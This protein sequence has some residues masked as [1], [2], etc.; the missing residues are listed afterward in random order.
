MSAPVFTVNINWNGDGS[1]MVDEVSRTIDLQITRGRSD[2]LQ[3]VQAGTCTLLM[4][5]DT[6]RFTP[7]Y[8]AGG[9]FGSLN[10]HK[11]VQIKVALGSTY[12]LFTGYITRIQ[13]MPMTR[14]CTITCQDKFLFL[15]NFHLN[16]AIV[17]SALTGDRITDVL[18]IVGLA[19]G[20]M[21]ID[22]GQVTLDHPYQRNTDALSGIYEYAASDLAGIVFIAAGGKVTYRDA[23]ARTLSTSQGTI[24][25]AQDI[26]YDRGEDN[27][28]TQIIL[29]GGSFDAGIVGSQVWSYSPLPLLLPASSTVVLNPN[30][31][32]PATAVITPVSGT[33]FIA[34]DAADGSGTDRSSLMVSTF[35]DYGGGAAWSITNTRDKDVYLTTI[36]VRG[37]PRGRNTS[38]RTVTRTG[39]SAPYVKTY[40]NSY[41]FITDLVTLAAFADYLASHFSLQQ[42]KVTLRLLPHVWDS[43]DGQFVQ[44]AAREINDRITLQDTACAYSSQINGDFFIESITHRI[45]LLNGSFETVWGLSTFANDQFFILDTSK[46]DSA[47]VLG[48]I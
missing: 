38:L 10:P 11:L 9:L 19:G 23:H 39:G 7:E 37:T 44:M 48:Y 22:A 3:D 47:D 2:A 24:T 8:A 12:N 43:S 33:D 35:T 13:P 40:Q 41:K 34:N 5:N 1:T 30:Y 36:G 29:Q 31:N 32:T 26:Q 14:T 45:S 20:D 21:D 4:R 17:A 27:V 46:L 42:P 28:F 25:S 18:T 15:K 6:G 16:E